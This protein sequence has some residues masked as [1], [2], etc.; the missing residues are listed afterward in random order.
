MDCGSD[1]QAHDRTEGF[2]CSPEE[3]GIVRV[4][5]FNCEWRRTDSSD[6]A[7]IRERV[8][9]G[10]TDVVCLTET[11]RDFPEGHGF[12]VTSAPLK[13]GPNIESWRKVLLWSRNPWTA[14]DAV[15]PPGLPEG[16]Y[17]AGTTSTPAGEV[18]VIG[19]IIPYG[20]AG[21]RFGSQSAALGSCT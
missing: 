7:I 4:A 6:A 21:V 20:F 16:R 5:T 14:V 17:V 18:R 9:D 13:A 15:D 12:A 1:E 11:H 19:V 8:M 3:S 10:S 2:G